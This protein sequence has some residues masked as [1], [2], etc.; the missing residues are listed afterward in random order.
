MDKLGTTMTKKGC[1]RNLQWCWG[2]ERG[3]K[4]CRSSCKQWL[5]ITIICA[6]KGFVI[7]GICRQF[8]FWTWSSRRSCNRCSWQCAKG[9]HVGP[10]PNG[11]LD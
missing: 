10:R 7:F 1:F 4:W 6:R 8:G 5:H 3:Y 2:G 11:R 9:E